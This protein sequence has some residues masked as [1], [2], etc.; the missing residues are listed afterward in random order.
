VPPGRY[1]RF[2]VV[3]GCRRNHETQSARR[4][5]ADG[6]VDAAVPHLVVPVDAPGADTGQDCYAMPGEAGHLRGWYSCVQGQ[7]DSAVPQVVWPGG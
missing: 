7:V 6:L 4:L 1:R 5:V 2:P 3:G